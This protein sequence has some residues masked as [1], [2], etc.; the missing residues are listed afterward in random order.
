MKSLDIT[1]IYVIGIRTFLPESLDTTF[2]QNKVVVV[3]KI[4]INFSRMLFRSLSV[5]GPP[6]TLFNRVGWLNI[7][8]GKNVDIRFHG[9]F[10]GVAAPEGNHIFLGILRGI[11]SRMIIMLVIIKAVL[12]LT[13]NMGFKESFRLGA[14]AMVNSRLVTGF[15]SSYLQLLN[16]M[17]CI[18]APVCN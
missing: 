3:R 4:C 18:V 10:N 12:D 17:I 2:I 7:Y 16:H 11:F 8:D 13:G 14:Y 9:I 5:Q 15:D 1:F 6:F